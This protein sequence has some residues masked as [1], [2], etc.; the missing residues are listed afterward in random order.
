MVVEK[1]QLVTFWRRDQGKPTERVD[2]HTGNV[3]GQQR[4]LD[5]G[6]K[7]LTELTGGGIQTSHQGWRQP[8]RALELITDHHYAVR[9]DIQMMAT[10][11]MVRGL[12]LLDNLPRLR[13]KQRQIGLHARQIELDTGKVGMGS[14]APVGNGQRLFVRHQAQFMGIH[15]ATGHDPQRAIPVHGI[16][17][18][19]TAL[20][21]VDV[22]GR[23][24]QLTSIGTEDRMA[25][26]V[27]TGPCLQHL[28]QL[29]IT[30]INHQGTTSGPAFDH[31][32]LITSG[33]LSTRMQ[34]P[35]NRLRL[36][37]GEQAAQQQVVSG[38]ITT[39]TGQ[40]ELACPRTGKCHSATA[41]AA[42]QQP[43]GG[44]G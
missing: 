29:T 33:T 42:R 4:Q 36:G 8:A 38:C 1:C 9:A 2:R 34:A 15:A 18:Q 13:I 10:E 37:G 40:S 21:R 6:N 24:I 14:N 43:H 11:L 17:D 19:N 26:K 35:G 7:R 16:K 25:I 12:V 5:L 32:Q 22:I 41:S 31:N 30:Q 20:A 44:P 3:I 28:N 27:Q 23:C 39:T